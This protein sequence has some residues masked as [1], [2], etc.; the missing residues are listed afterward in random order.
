VMVSS[1]SSCSMETV[2]SSSLISFNGGEYKLISVPY[3]LAPNTCVGPMTVTVSVYES[4]R[5]L[6]NDSTSLTVQ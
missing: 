6:A 3:P 4:G 5:M 1:V 2:V